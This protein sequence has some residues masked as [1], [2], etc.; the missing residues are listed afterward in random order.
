M[1]F[2]RAKWEGGLY[3][4]KVH[5]S[6]LGVPSVVASHWL[7]CCQARTQSSVVLLGSKVIIFLLGMQGMQNMCLGDVPQL[8]TS[9]RV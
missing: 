2:Y 4:Q 8:L 9:G 6:K 5:W 7:G 3:K 1:L